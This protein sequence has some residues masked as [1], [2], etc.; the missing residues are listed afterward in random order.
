M[1]YRLIQRRVPGWF[2]FNSLHVM[3]P[4]YTRKTNE[5]I[6]RDMGTIELY[7]LDVPKA[8]RRPVVVT[9][10]SLSK[11]VLI[12]RRCFIVPWRPTLNAIFPGKED[13]TTYMLGGDKPANTAQ[14]NLV[15]DIL[16]GPADF[17]SLLSDFVFKSSCRYL[18]EFFQPRQDHSTDRHY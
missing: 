13:Y 15:G 8:P 10:H 12:D 11:Q 14:R 9:K 4:M 3:Q 1:L 16:Y 18:K 5:Q 17:K 2:P 7:T 6:A